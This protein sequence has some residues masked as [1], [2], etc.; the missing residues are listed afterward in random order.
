MYIRK[1]IL[2]V[3]NFILYLCLNT[4]INIPRYTVED[5]NNIMDSVTFSTFKEAQE[6]L[7]SK[8]WDDIAISPYDALLR[9]KEYIF[10]KTGTNYQNSYIKI[11]R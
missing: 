10:A 3:N 6:Y 9:A 7:N 5:S 4:D 8:E 2:K 1:E 11:L